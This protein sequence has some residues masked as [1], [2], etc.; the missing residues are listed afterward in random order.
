MAT[1]AVTAPLQALPG[2][3]NARDL[4]DKNP[5]QPPQLIKGLLHQGS[6]MVLGGGSKSYKTWSLLDLGM[7]VSSGEPWWGFETTQAK[8]LYINLELPDW[9]FKAR[10]DEITNAR[11]ELMDVSQFDIWN[12]RGHSAS[13]E[14]MRPQIVD[15]VGEGY[16]LIII[17]PIYK[18]YGNR[19]ENSAGEMGNLLNEIE[20]LAVKTNAAVAFGAHFS[21]GNQAGKESIDR[22]SGSGVFGRDP[23]TILVM[24]KHELDDT[25]TVEATL[26]NLKAVPSFCVQRTHPLMERNDALDPEKLKQPGFKKKYTEA[27]LIDVLDDQSLLTMGWFN[28]ASHKLGISKRCFLNKLKLMKEDATQVVQGADEKWSTLAVAEQKKEEVERNF[29]TREQCLGAKTVFPPLTCPSTFKPGICSRKLEN[30]LHKRFLVVESDTLDR[31]VVGAIFR[32][33]RDE[34]HLNLRVIVDTGG[35]SLHAWFDYPLELWPDLKL[36]LPALGCDRSMFIPCLPCR[37]LGVGR[38][39]RFQRLIYQR[40]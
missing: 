33:L 27:H 39:G 40:G 1:N 11:L 9:S 24:T 38:N 22:I 7:S 30:I 36:V 32:W 12:L 21:K 28:Q 2:I 17:D 29:R 18:V 37:M 15:R 23:D 4:I 16:G 20:C 19:D 6:K 26:R 10:I 34:N 14:K 8:V 25:Y 5:P 3:I 35:K 13:F 31:D